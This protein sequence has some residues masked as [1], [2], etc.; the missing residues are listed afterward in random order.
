MIEIPIDFLFDNY[1]QL[2]TVQEEYNNLNNDRYIVNSF[3]NSVSNFDFEND[4]L[5]LEK[6][7]VKYTQ[8]IKKCFFSK[9]KKGSR[10]LLLA[11]FLSKTH[12]KYKKIIPVTMDIS[13]TLPPTP[14]TNFGFDPNLLR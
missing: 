13:F 9:I 2:H 12:F 10:F 11:I 7:N 6:N 3:P 14:F 5:D 8:K 4:L 1:S